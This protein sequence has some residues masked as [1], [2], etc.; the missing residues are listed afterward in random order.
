VKNIR[1][2]ST[3]VSVPFPFIEQVKLVSVMGVKGDYAGINHWNVGQHNFFPKYSEFVH[4]LKKRRVQQSNIPAVPIDS[5]E[6]E[7]HKRKMVTVIVGDFLAQHTEAAV[8]PDVFLNGFPKHQPPDGV[9]VLHPYLTDIEDYKP[10]KVSEP[11]HHYLNTLLLSESNLNLCTLMMMD[12]DF[13]GFLSG[14]WYCKVVGSFFRHHLEQLFAPSLNVCYGGATTWWCI[15][16]KDFGKY[17]QFLSDFVKEKLKVDEDKGWS[18]KQSRLLLALLYAKKTFIDPRLLA[19][20]DAGIEVFQLNQKAGDVVMLDGDIVH[21]GV[22]SEDHS[23]N[24][25]I[26]FIPVSW[27]VN[28]LPLLKDWMEWLEGFM[29]DEKE[30][31][32][33]FGVDWDQVKL[34]V[35][36][37]TV[38]HHVGKHCPR[39]FTVE[40]LSRVKRSIQYG[41]QQPLVV[42]REG[43]KREEDTSSI[44][45][46]KRKRPHHTTQAEVSSEPQL[47]AIDYGELSDE[48]LKQSISHID[49]IVNFLNQED[50][51]RWYHN[52]SYGNH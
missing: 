43:E 52:N 37:E 10:W 39:T 1:V 27:L 48:E 35:F 31:K 19:E 34:V 28:G 16:R 11:F 6:G 23:I 20:S 18:D 42:T 45:S 50:V 46:K 24:E 29:E 44:G 3:M 15:R 30:L 33:L 41:Q 5:P 2:N 32:D 47:P 7:A 51:Q 49:Y 40:F 14:S 26:N 25:A 22:C 17:K 4:T 21:L 38:K 12:S 9:A 8:S 36:S 13:P